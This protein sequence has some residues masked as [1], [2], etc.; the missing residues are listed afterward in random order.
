MLPNTIVEGQEKKMI[1]TVD[2][3][4]QTYY[5]D[6]EYLYVGVCNRVDTIIKYH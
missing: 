5:S 4:T 3:V 2:F 1:F 6:T